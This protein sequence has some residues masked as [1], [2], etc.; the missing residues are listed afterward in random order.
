[1]KQSVECKFGKRHTS[2]N[3]VM[4]IGEHATTQVSYFKNVGPTTQN[5]EGIEGDV[6]HKICV[7]WTK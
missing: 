1:M 2:P 5:E 7:E 6:K 3:L 4:K